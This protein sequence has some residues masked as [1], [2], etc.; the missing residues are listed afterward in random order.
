MRAADLLPQAE[1]DPHRVAAEAG[2]ALVNGTTVMTSLPGLALFDSVYLARLCVAA[3]AMSVEAL[4][5]TTGPFEETIHRAKN[6]PGQL[7]GRQCS[8]ASPKAAA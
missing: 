6:H 8:V 1:I 5:A 3:V 4:R 2:L 7:E